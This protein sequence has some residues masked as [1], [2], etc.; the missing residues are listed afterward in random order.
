MKIPGSALSASQEKKFINIINRKH[1]WAWEHKWKFSGEKHQYWKEWLGW[2]EGSGSRRFAR[3]LFHPNLI[4]PTIDLIAATYIGESPRAF[5]TPVE[6]NDVDDCE[7]ANQ[8]YTIDWDVTSVDTVLYL[9]TVSSLVFGTSAWQRRYDPVQ[10]R[11]IRVYADPRHWA[12]DPSSDLSGQSAT[13]FSH[14]FIKPI[15][16]ILRKYPDAFEDK[17]G[18]EID[19]G[20]LDFLAQDAF[21]FQPNQAIPLIRPK[22]PPGT[23]ASVGDRSVFGVETDIKA[24]AVFLEFWVRDICEFDFLLPD[25]V[26]SEIKRWSSPGAI[27]KA[28]GGRVLEIA[29]NPF[30]DGQIPY[31]FLRPDP[32]PEG[33]YGASAVYPLVTCQINSDILHTRFV[34]YM[35][36]VVSP[37]YVYDTQI[38]GEDGCPGWIP[39][40]IDYVLKVKGGGRALTQLNPQGPHAIIFEFLQHIINLT[41]RISGANEASQGIR[42]EG[43]IAA[44]AIEE[45]RGSFIARSEPRRRQILS[46]VQHDGAGYIDMA[47]IYY[48]QKFMDRSLGKAQAAGWDKIRKDLAGKIDFHAQITSSNSQNPK[49]TME[50]GMQLLDRGWRNKKTPI[51]VREE[52]AIL[53]KP[54]YAGAARELED[55]KKEKRFLKEQAASGPPA[56]MNEGQGTP[57]PQP[58]APPETTE[59]QPAGAMY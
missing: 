16:E 6:K 33:F 18:R 27:I 24:R 38:G 48:D 35:K 55:I 47:A 3:N 14:A 44:R 9:A 32:S 43:I 54:F 50:L 17:P 41:Q 45:L 39:H 51:E 57:S 1:Q 22:N 25:S 31:T 7:I 37:P 2:Y 42:P 26:R 29:Q 52:M 58:P 49:Q 15:D 56:E 13:F 36:K 30:A 11:V 12:I 23:Y 4:K 46:G 19:M 40:D 5:Y 20:M 21:I 8:I 53:A 10:K 59:P 34:E 28:A